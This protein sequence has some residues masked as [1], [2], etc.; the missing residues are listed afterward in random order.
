MAFDLGTYQF[1]E[2]M[3]KHIVSEERVSVWLQTEGCRD[4]GGFV[5]TLTQACRSSK[6]TET[7]LTD[8]SC[9]FEELYGGDLTDNFRI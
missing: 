6:M 9:P 2:T 5:Q 3:E 1:Q 8:V 4:L 7:V